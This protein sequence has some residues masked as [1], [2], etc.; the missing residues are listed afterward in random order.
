MATKEDEK[1][2]AT[3]AEDGPVDA[4]FVP[5]E[6]AALAKSEAS[7][8]ETDEEA[9][10]ERDLVPTQL[11]ATK[12]VHAAF[13]AAGIG[14]AY[15]SGKILAALWNML[16]DWPPAVRAVPQLLRYAEDQRATITMIAGAV[17]GVIGV[18]QAY[19]KE[20]IRRWADD[21]AT[22][23]SK[24]KWP[25]RQEVVNGTVV[26]VIASAIATVYVALLD[27]LWGFLTTLVYGA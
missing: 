4:E 11:G 23:L 19:R 16:A 2:E 6:G 5:D 27:R 13:F 22:E 10:D 21:V 8:A 1:D 9:E 14:V 17:I 25:D 12:Y 15:L 24:C 7:A 3:P 26:V 20:G 18:I